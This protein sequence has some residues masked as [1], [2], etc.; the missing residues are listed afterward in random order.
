MQQANFIPKTYA[1]PLRQL[2]GQVGLHLLHQYV[3]TVRERD[4]AVLVDDGF[5][6]SGLRRRYNRQGFTA[7]LVGKDGGEKL[8]RRGVLD[9]NTLSHTIDAM[10]MRQHETREK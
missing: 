9:V 2:A 10:P 5:P 1:I 6:H 7:I 3:A 8:R 4:I